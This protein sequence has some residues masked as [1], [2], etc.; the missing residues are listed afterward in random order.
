M[1]NIIKSVKRKTAKPSWKIKALIPMA[2]F[3][4]FTLLYPL[5]VQAYNNDADRSNE[6]TVTNIETDPPSF[7]EKW[8]YYDRGDHISVCGYTGTEGRI[9]IPSE[10]DGKPV[11]EISARLGT[12]G[13]PMHEFF[14][15]YNGSGT[16]LTIPEG[17]LSIAQSAFEG[18]QIL[19]S[20][21]LPQSLKFIGNRAF[22]YCENLTS[23]T[24]PENLTGI[25]TYA[26]ARTGFTE[27][28]LPEGLKIIGEGAFMA[29]ANLTKIHIPDSVISIGREAFFSTNIE[30]ITLPAGLDKLTSS[31]LSGCTRLKRVYISEGTEALGSSLFES[32]PNLEEVYFPSTLKEIDAIF[33]YNL[34]L[35]NLYFAAGEEETGQNIGANILGGLIGDYDDGSEEKSP[36]ITYYYENVIITYN[37]P[38]PTS[39]EGNFTKPLNIDKTTVILIAASTACL[40]LSAVF[41][42]LFIK[43]KKQIEAAKAERAKREEE[44]FHPE[45]LGAWECEKCGTINSSIGNYCYKC[46]RKR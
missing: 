7:W 32:C 42:I 37:T 26:F 21:S 45:V 19:K 22:I 10:I 1:I 46:G 31:L 41:L 3:C 8:L 27:I 36:D 38:V 6:S 16:S 43:G 40:I 9:A 25:G 23:I 33:S 20:I 29:N 15:D 13:Y 39:E 17:V 12:D 2:F 5:H 4:I 14:E 30:E 18:S 28:Y 34:K 11:T 35:K 44:G 24:F